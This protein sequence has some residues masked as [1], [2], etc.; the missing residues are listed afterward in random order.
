VPG[1]ELSTSPFEPTTHWEQVYL[2]LMD[3]MECSA[4]DELAVS[5]QSDL[6]NYANIGMD[7]R[8]QTQLKRGG[9]LIKFF[10]SQPLQRIKNEN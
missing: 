1:I 3:P 4:N 5:L 7:F 8:W 9:K 6:S 2:P 10:E